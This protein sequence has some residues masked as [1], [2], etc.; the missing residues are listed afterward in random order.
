MKV[1]CAF[2]I[3][4]FSSVSP[5]ND[6]KK[7]NIWTGKGQQMSLMSKSR[8]CVCVVVSQ[9]NANSDDDFISGVIN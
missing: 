2:S 4:F 8:F 1:I 6:K 9:Q 3:Y 5:N 7:K